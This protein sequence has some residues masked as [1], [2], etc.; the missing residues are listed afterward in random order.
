MAHKNDIG[1]TPS[2]EYQNEQSDRL[3]IDT[4]HSRQTTHKERKMAMSKAICVFVMEASK[5]NVTLMS[6][7]LRSQN[8]MFWARRITR[9]MI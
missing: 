6:L 5:P 7:E 9:R 1:H 3:G 8:R 4:Y 2:V